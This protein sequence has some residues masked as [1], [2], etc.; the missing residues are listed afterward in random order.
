MARPQQF[1][2]QQVLNEAMQLFWLKGYANTSIKD[3]TEVTRL[4]PGSLYGAFKNKQGLFKEA[5]DSYFDTVYS[6]VSKILLS[7][8]DGLQRIRQFFEYVI[9]NME[10]DEAT[11]SCLMVN[12]L[13]ELPANDE[14]ISHRLN[15]MFGKIEALFNQ[16][17]IDAQ[18]NGTLAAEAEPESMAKM[19]MSSLMGLQVYNKMQPGQ[20]ALKQIVR[21][22]LSILEKSDI[23]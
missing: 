18:K 5:L 12:T 4:Q 7:E 16:A 21:N 20:D 10:R 11:K 22:Q 13:L 8:E 17:L 9:S 14:I 23:R 2:Y 19:L 3:L 1:D 15:I 6:E